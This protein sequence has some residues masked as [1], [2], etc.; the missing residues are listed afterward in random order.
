[1][2]R[3]YIYLTTKLKN[4]KIDQTSGEA[5]SFN[6]KLLR[7]PNVPPITSLTLTGSALSKY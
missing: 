1:M 5:P 3:G 6:L 7:I 4:S 2:K